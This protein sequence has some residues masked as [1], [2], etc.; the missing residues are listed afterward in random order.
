[1]AGILLEGDNVTDEQRAAY[2]RTLAAEKREVSQRRA[3]DVTSRV[4]DAKIEHALRIPPSVIKDNEIAPGGYY[5]ATLSSSD[6]L[7]I[8]DL[9]GRQAVDFLCYDAHDPENRYN[10]A[11]TI[12]MKSFHLCGQRVQALFRSRRHSHDGSRRYRRSA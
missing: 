5:T 7:R 6:H 9:E 4:G 11:N 2:A 12:K 10:A 3:R 8:I 1:M